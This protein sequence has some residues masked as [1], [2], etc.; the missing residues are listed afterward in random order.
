MTVDILYKLITLPREFSQL[1]TVSMYDLLKRTGYADL[2]KSISEDDLYE[3]LLAHP[4][5]ITDWLE[6]SE[7][8][9]CA[10]WYFRSSNSDRY[11]VGYYGNGESFETEYSDKLKACAVFIKHELTNILKIS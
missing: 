8:K 2:S 1:N 5:V 4:E 10:G 11:L 3:K 7:D 6:Y 9:R